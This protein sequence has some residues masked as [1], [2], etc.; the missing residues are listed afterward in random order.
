[1]TYWLIFSG[2]VTELVRRRGTTTAADGTLVG[3]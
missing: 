2:V 1:M 3:K